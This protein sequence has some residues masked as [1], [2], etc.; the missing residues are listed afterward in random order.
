MSEKKASSRVVMVAG[1]FGIAAL[2]VFLMSLVSLAAGGKGYRGADPVPDGSKSEITFLEKDKDFNVNLSLKL[3]DPREKD[4]DG[5]DKIIEGLGEQDI[6]VYENGDP[7]AFTSFSPAGK[8]PVRLALVIDA[9]QTMAANNKIGFARDASLALLRMLTERDHFGLFLFNGPR[10]ANNTVQVMPVKP[11]L[12]VDPDG[13]KPGHREVAWQTL[14]AGIPLS[15]DTP[16][17]RGIQIGIDGVK[18]V[19]GRRVVIVLTDGMTTEEG[20]ELKQEKEKLLTK[21][22]ELKLALYMVNVDTDPITEASDKDKKAADALMG[23]LSEK[24]GGRYFRTAKPEELRE[25][26][27]GIGKGLQNEYGITYKSPTPRDDGVVRKVTVVARTSKGGGTKARSEYVVGGAAGAVAGS[28]WKF[29]GTLATIFVALAAGLAG[30]A[31][32]PT[33][34]GRRVTGE[35]ASAAA[36]PAPAAAPVAVTAT[37]PATRPASPPQPRR[38]AKM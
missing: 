27:I 14:Y 38:P 32:G 34:M 19:P 2:W 12:L 25:I 13:Q 3:T 5:K 30:L 28:G 8:G 1:L 17:L 24:T 31:L 7:V 6:D 26:F 4:K 9:T 21:C 35:E 23:D 10:I 11:L 22:Q 29:L 37:P 33:I 15:N 20:D 18:D 16:M 36:A